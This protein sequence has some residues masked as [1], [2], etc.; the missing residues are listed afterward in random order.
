M[1]S[2]SYFNFVSLLI[3][4]AASSEAS[5]VAALHTA[6]N[7]FF[8][9]YFRTKKPLR[10]QVPYAQT[11]LEK[12]FRCFP[13][14]RSAILEAIT[15]HPTWMPAY[16]VQCSSNDV[17]CVPAS[18]CFEAYISQRTLCTRHARAAAAA[19]ALC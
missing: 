17:R 12:L 8:N 14:T 15:S 11:V 16:L 5:S 2:T 10:D 7:F 18:A 6:L 3:D 13:V 1:F 4:Q 9:V 19:D